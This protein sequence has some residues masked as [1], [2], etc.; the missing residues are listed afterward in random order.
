MPSPSVELLSIDG[1]T[2]GQHIDELSALYR[3]VYAE[4]PYGWGDEH[5]ALFGQWFDGQRRQDGFTLIEAREHGA[6]VAM[7]FGVTL[8]PNTPWWQNLVKPVADGVTQEYP[9]RTFAL[10]ELLVRAPWRRRHIAEYVHDLLLEDRIE[11]R[12]TLT[13]LPA[14]EAAQA[15]YRKWGWRK[16]A[17]KRNP[18]PGA[19]VFD[20]LVRELVKK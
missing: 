8:L 9:N 5:V 6:L 4:A 12:A 10:V 7:G 11:Q 2:A 1:Q 3:E 18:L 13:V 17:Q 20:V 19:P 14:A 15:A 16:V